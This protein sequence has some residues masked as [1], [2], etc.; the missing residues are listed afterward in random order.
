[1]GALLSVL[2]LAI[3]ATPAGA[4]RTSVAGYGWSSP[5]WSGYAAVTPT[6]LTPTS[7]TAVAGRWVQPAVTCGRGRSAAAFWLGFDGY[8]NDTVEQIGTK[9]V[10]EDGVPTYV[11]W[12]QMWPAP[13]HFLSASYSVRA[14]DV[15]AA[16]VTRSGD[17]VTLSLRSSAGWRF[18]AVARAE[19][20]SASAEWIASAPRQCATCRFA[21]LADFHTASFFD[22]RVS[23]GGP[24]VPISVVGR[25]GDLVALTMERPGQEALSR[26]SAVSSADEG[27]TVEWED[28]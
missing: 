2:L 28:P 10:C 15:L 19:V 13:V 23:T 12:W 17:V 8:R 24:T 4:D 25:R 1:M 3:A 14:S 6:S 20:A 9:A 7:F 26:P 11:A 21:P 27:F 22:A 5:N 16:S 18:Q